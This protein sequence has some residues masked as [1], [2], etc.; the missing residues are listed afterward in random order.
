MNISKRSFEKNTASILAALG[1]PFRVRIALAL[2]E[3]EACVCHL[4]K[5][6]QKRQAYISQHLMVLREAGL[7][8]TRRDGKYIYYRLASSSVLDLVRSAAE[9]AGIVP[10]DFP[11]YQA[12]DFLEKCEC[13]NCGYDESGHPTQTNAAHTVKISSM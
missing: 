12:P 9:L 7:L 2:G 3:Q 6:L 8:E 13:P 4:E 11:A 10:T 5:L 1:N